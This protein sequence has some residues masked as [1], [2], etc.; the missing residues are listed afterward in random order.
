[1]N[2]LIERLP[3]LLTLVEEWKPVV[4]YEDFYEV[5]NT[6]KVR[7]L[8]RIDRSG[9]RRKGQEMRSVKKKGTGHLRV[10]L[11]RDGKKKHLFVHRLV[12]QAFQGEIAEGLVVR[13]LTDDPDQNWL[14]LLE[15]GSVADNSADTIRNGRCF[16]TNLHG[17]KTHCP[18]GHQLDGINLV[19]S[20]LEK[21]K[22]KCLACDRASNRNRKLGL[23]VDSPEFQALSDE[24][25]RA[26][27]AGFVSPERFYS[28]VS[29]TVT[30]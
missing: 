14:P 19:P 23:A 9:R 26:N 21:G 5:S 25:Y 15:Q 2:L 18:R 28:A 6:G 13:H 1:M 30:S 7:S 4:G 20:Q 8:D 10:G 16:Y 12:V 3:Q 22:R 24:F 11:R 29:A 17:S 27:L